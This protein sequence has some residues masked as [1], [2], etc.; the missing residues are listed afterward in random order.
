M[1]DNL[2][3]YLEELSFC[4]CITRYQDTGIVLPTTLK[5]CN[6]KQVRIVGEIPQVTKL[7]IDY[8]C[9]T[10]N[11]PKSLKV[12]K[13]QVDQKDVVAGMIPNTCTDVD[14]YVF[15]RLIVPVGTFP[16]H[17]AKLV[18][19]SSELHIE[20]D[21]LPKT[22]HELHLNADRIF[23][24]PNQ[25]CIVDTLQI[26]VWNKICDH[27]PVT[28]VLNLYQQVSNYDITSLS[29]LQVLSC[30]TINLGDAR[31]MTELCEMTLKHW[32]VP[33]THPPPLQKLSI[34]RFRDSPFQ[35]KL[36]STLKTLQLGEMMEALPCDWL[37]KG[38]ARLQFQ[39][40]YKERLSSNVLPI[41]LE[42]LVGIA[43][44]T[45]DVVLPVEL[46]MLVLNESCKFWKQNPLP[47]KLECL[48]LRNRK[49]I[50]LLEEGDLPDSLYF[51]RVKTTQTDH[52]ERLVSKLPR[53]RLLKAR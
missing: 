24:P 3:E 37:P 30:Q 39:S 11:L 53:C 16:N 15:P 1:I 46:K 17:M 14:L 8:W 22:V 31:F 20:N 36:P 32:D 41:S 29:R 6:L 50:P 45:I 13:V 52:I 43:P 9:G 12:L 49:V 38:L 21:A 23:C 19:G 2:P 42:E 27:M 34:K 40:G 48:I 4:A 28:R 33:W 25:Q 51:V 7:S 47:T 18:I 10:K 26:T 5:V 44:E 35:T